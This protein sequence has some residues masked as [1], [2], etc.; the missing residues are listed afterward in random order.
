VERGTAINDGTWHLVTG[1]LGV[2]DALSKTKTSALYVDGVQRGSMPGGGITNTP[3]QDIYIGGSLPSTY[4]LVGE[5][6]DVGIWDHGLWASEATAL[7]SVAV[8]PDL[9]YN[10]KQ[11]QQLFDVHRAYAGGTTIG[12][13]NWK[14]SGSL[15]GNLGEVVKTGSVYTIRLDDNGNGVTTGTASP[16]DPPEPP[17]P[18]PRPPV[19]LK[20]HWALDEGSGTVA[21]DSAG[22]YPGT[23]GG[24]SLVRNQTIGTTVYNVSHDFSAPTWT[25]GKLGGGLSFAGGPYNP[26]GTNTSGTFAAGDAVVVPL[27]EEDLIDTDL[28]VALW[29]KTTQNA[30]WVAL[31][32]KGWGH[33]M[34]DPGGWEFD[35]RLDSG[36][37]PQVMADVAPP[38]W[39]K[40]DNTRIDDGQWHS[41][42]FSYFAET[43]ELRC[44]IDGKA[45]LVTEDAVLGQT[46]KDI[47]FG[48]D[49]YSSVHYVGALDDVG[50]WSGVLTDG[51][52]KAIYTL[53]LDA[54]L[55]YDLGKASSL[56][57]IAQAKS[58]YVTFGSLTWSCATGLTG[59]IGDVVKAGDDYFL[60]L[61]ADGNGVATGF[62]PGNPGDAN[63]DGVVNDM[64]ASILGAHWLAG[65]A[66]WAMGD[67]NADGFVNDKDAAIMA[68]HWGSVAGESSV[69][70]PGTM[71]MLASILAIVG[72]KYSTRK[73]QA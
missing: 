45:P 59:G 11:A 25:A 55:G 7:Y 19:Q 37:A 69:P 29:A 32:S 20:S 4:N 42:V 73:R 68:A 70:E 8:Q 43:K 10:L 51:E 31:V 67:F 49:A 28:S 50:Y 46:V 62:E 17:P 41:L 13:L 16:T 30:N 44:Y 1:T 38:V 57:E 2:T 22:S 39:Y 34:G 12:S 14:A 66:T 35:T 3:L 21:G 23:L 27:G 36:V 5:I 64:D 18:P 61:D 52:A 63:G 9:Q 53:A 60:R 15:V 47:I 65:G 54:G 58:G 33:N 72:V 6:D 56:F 71:A 48:G 24:T 40:T 26:A